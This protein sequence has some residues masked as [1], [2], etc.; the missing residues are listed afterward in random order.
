M[1]DDEQ[2]KLRGLFLSEDEIALLKELRNLGGM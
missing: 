2:M 1:E